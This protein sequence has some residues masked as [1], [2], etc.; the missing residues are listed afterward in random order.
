MKVITIELLN[1]PFCIK[2]ND[3]E[4]E[5]LKHA[6]N[7]LNAKMQETRHKF[8]TLDN[9]Q[10]LMLAALN[11]SSD[12]VK[13]KQKSSDN[14]NKMNNIVA[15]LEAKIQSTLTNAENNVETIEI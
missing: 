7:L 1:Q 6:A 3:D 8:K 12:L 4:V 14:F 11:I 2:C 5:S 9:S 10:T 13:A 15:A